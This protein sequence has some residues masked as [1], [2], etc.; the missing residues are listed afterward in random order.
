VARRKLNLREVSNR[1]VLDAMDRVPRD[2]FVPPESRAEAFEDRPVPIGFGQ[3]ISQPYI[4][5]LMTELLEPRPTDKVLEIG[6]GS[7]YQAAILSLLVREVYTVERIEALATAARER[8]QRL[9]YDNVHV[10]V[11]D[12]YDGWP[13]HAPYDGIMVTS[14][15]S[16]MPP[17]LLK[18]LADG[19][20]LVAPVGPPGGMQNLVVLTKRGDAFQRHEIAGV[21]FVPLLRGTDA[22]E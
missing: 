13:E 9:G 4:V 17:P 18:Q 6:T 14:A 10:H 11:G 22:G 15:A 8:L 2:E 21:C 5:A 12:G 3:T 16:D 7:G 1:R 20:H 19:G